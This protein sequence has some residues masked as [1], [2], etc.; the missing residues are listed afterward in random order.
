MPARAGTEQWELGQQHDD[1]RHVILR[2]RAQLH[3]IGKLGLQVTPVV[4]RQAQR[5]GR[6][7]PGTALWWLDDLVGDAAVRVGDAVDELGPA[8][9][10]GTIRD[11]VHGVAMLR[12]HRH[13]RLKVPQEPEILD[14]EENLHEWVIS[15]RVAR[16]D[17]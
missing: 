3:G 13:G 16:S 7:N 11:D 8:N 6:R 4:D 5:H 17:R 15:A 14:A 9:A 10:V 1:A 12:Q 2:A